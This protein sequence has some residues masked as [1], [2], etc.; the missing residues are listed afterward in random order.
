MTRSRSRSKP[1]RERTREY[2]VTPTCVV[3]GSILRF[4]SLVAVLIKSADLSHGSAR[5]RRHFLLYFWHQ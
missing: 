5:V 4:S 2:E 3:L 1:R